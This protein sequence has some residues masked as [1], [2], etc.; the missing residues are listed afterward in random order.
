M[1][2]SGCYTGSSAYGYMPN[3]SNKFKYD[4]NYAS[5]YMPTFNTWSSSSS[6]DYTSGY[7]TNYSTGSKKKSKSGNG[8]GFLAKLGSWGSKAWNYVKGLGK[9][10]IKTA[11]KYIGYNEANGSYKKF[12]NGRTEAWCADFV[13]YVTKEAFK[14]A[15]KTLPAGF[16]SASVSGLRDW[17]IKTGRY[18]QTSG[19]SNKSS[20][21]AKNVKPGD[22]II[23]KD[24]GASHTG[25]VEKVDS[26]GTIHTIEG[27]TSDRVARRT[28]A[29]NNG[30]ISGFIHMA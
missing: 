3:T 18:M 29:A 1:P 13:T 20:L 16:G 19:K 30:R 21:I 27:N 24:Q 28:Y 26:N 5:S 12:T 11:A 7:K 22:I 9:S 14:A 23:F 2:I 17:G 15:G 4:P 10:I 25:I 8:S 6:L